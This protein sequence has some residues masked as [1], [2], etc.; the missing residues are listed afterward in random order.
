MNV[1]QQ[2]QYSPF[3]KKPK[4]QLLRKKRVKTKTKRRKKMQKCVIKSKKK[5]K[6]LQNYFINFIFG[7]IKTV[8][9]NRVHFFMAS[10]AS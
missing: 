1:E 4:M 9:I 7:K 5:I 10:V 3:E 6:V 2:Q 8:K